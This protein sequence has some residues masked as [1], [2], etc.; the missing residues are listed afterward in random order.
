LHFP[1]RRYYFRST[2]ETNQKNVKLV[3][4]AHLA[5]MGDSPVVFCS[6]Q[7]L[8]SILWWNGSKS[9]ANMNGPRVDYIQFQ[10]TSSDHAH[11]RSAIRLTATANAELKV[12]FL[13]LRPQRYCEGNVSSKQLIPKKVT[14]TGTVARTTISA[15]R[16]W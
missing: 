11:L 10:D 15:V 12:G 8:E 16:G 3:A 14:G 6:D 9:N 4:D 7:Y 1:L 13:N 5:N 2:V